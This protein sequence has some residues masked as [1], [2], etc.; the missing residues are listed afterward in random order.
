MSATTIFVWTIAHRPWIMGGR[1]NG[2]VKVKLDVVG[3]IDLGKGARVG[4]TMSPAGT[5]WYVELVSGGLMGKEL[6]VIRA[7]VAEADPDVI[8]K[9]LEDGK[10]QCRTADVVSSDEFWGL[11]REV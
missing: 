7:D 10:E 8:S 4:L 1:V 9:Q 5:P 2:P 11:L 3:D 6:E